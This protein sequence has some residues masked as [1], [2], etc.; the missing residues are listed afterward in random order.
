[1]G[2]L[3]TVGGG[4]GGDGGDVGVIATQRTLL[5]R[6]LVSSS[7]SIT[8]SLSSSLTTKISIAVTYSPH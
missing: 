2:D 7:S 8:F 1:M 4:G 3:R 6:V 5:A